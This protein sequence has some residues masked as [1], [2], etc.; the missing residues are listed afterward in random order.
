MPVVKAGDLETFYLDA[1]T[2]AP[3]VLLHGNWGSSTWWEPVL[4]RLPAG[5]RGLAPDMRG[6]GQTHGP[7]GDYRIPSLA[8]DV[9]AFADAARLDHFDLVGH[10]LGSCVAIEVALT[11]PERLR[12]LVL[13]SPGWIDGMPG[14][15]AVPERQKQLKED[16]AF[17]AMALRAIT[18]G[19]DDDL[20][21]RLLHDAGEQRLAAAIALLPALTEWKPGN[22]VGAIRAPRVVISGEL[23]LF[24]G[25]PNAVR[26]A[27]A[28]GCELITMSNV[29][30]GPMIEAPEAFAKILWK[31]LSPL[32]VAS[33]A[34]R[35]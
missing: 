4:A 11:H 6:R 28:L 2:G 24:T 7:D 14:A 3:L 19:P 22:A 13:V 18:P 33:R 15:Y 26:V 8:A 31:Y 30:H 20:W 23:D 12:S 21:R 35:S 1:G 16:P 32:E 10:S 25:G 9:I 17:L 27:Q 34:V 29:N 5:R